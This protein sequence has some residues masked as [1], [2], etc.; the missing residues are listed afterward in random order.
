MFDLAPLE[1][2]PRLSRE[3]AA[4]LVGIT[5][6][7][8]DRFMIGSGVASDDRG[9]SIL[10]LLRAGYA[11]LARKEVQAAMIGQQLSRALER[12]KQ[13]VATLQ[14]RVLKDPPPPMTDDARPEAMAVASEPKKKKKKKKKNR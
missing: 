8:L 12:E 9:L 10:Q 3:E 14:S 6:E 11:L 4:W 1:K 5:P 13:L 2:W 7:A